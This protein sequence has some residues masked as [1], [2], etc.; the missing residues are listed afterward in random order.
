VLVK[1]DWGWIPDRFA[2]RCG[3]VRRFAGNGGWRGALF[4]FGGTRRAVGVSAVPGC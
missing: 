3:A 1:S 2:R 4:R